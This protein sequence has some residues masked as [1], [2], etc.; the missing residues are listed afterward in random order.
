MMPDDSAAITAR[1]IASAF[2][3][4]NTLGAGFLEK[5]YERALMI[6][7]RNQGL[8]VQAQVRTSVVYSGEVVGEYVADL[9][10]ERSVVAEVKATEHIESAF[11]AQT[12]NYMKAL[13]LRT[14]LILNF[15]TARLGIKRLRL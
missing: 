4:S 8:S 7:M 12:L 9:V 13:H 14:G 1:I 3:V 11:V 2:E 10:V 6:E 15:G 5:V